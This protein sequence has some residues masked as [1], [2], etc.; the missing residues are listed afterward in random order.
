MLT[1]IET[2]AQKYVRAKLMLAEAEELVESTRD[3]LMEILPPGEKYVTKDGET[4]AHVAGNIRHAFVADKL[5]SLL[6]ARIWKA[7]RID[8]IDA[9]KL[10]AYMEAGEVTLASIRDGVEDVPIKAHLRLNFGAKV[11]TTKTPTATRKVA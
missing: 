1:K 5:K 8:A 2:A 6:P 11:P 3:D 10:K 4:V 7:V 9:K